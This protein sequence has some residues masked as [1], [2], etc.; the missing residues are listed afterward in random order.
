MSS[1]ERARVGRSQA[2]PA[3]R[4]TEI[5]GN[6]SVQ[7]HGDR[8][9]LQRAG[10]RRSQ[11][12]PASRNTEIAGNSSVQ[13]H[14]DRRQLQRAGTRRSQATPACRNTEIAG[15]SSE[16]ARRSQ[17]ITTTTD[18][19]PGQELSQEKTWGSRYLVFFRSGQRGGPDLLDPLAG[20]VLGPGGSS[21]W[22]ALD[23]SYGFSQSI[24][25]LRGPVFS[26]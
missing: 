24:V 7:E 6:S 19:R 26:G 16:Q 12:T 8:R 2:T 23:N 1:H 9:Q 13:E 25:E 17:T 3:C 18:R 20:Y 15:N 10:T 4:N 22:D 5:A 14:G 11:A 21:V